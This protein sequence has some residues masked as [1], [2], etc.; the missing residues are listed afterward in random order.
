[1]NNSDVPR[2]D[3][4]NEPSGETGWYEDPFKRHA[5]R[6]IS[7]G[8]ATSLVRDASAP[9]SDEPPDE[10]IRQP[11]VEAPYVP[12][13][14]DLTRA[15]DGTDPET[16]D[17]QETPGYDHLFPLTYLMRKYRERHTRDSS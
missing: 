14:H 12:G 13:P 1:M 17:N 16:E 6:W 15:G 5:F 2:L 11:L 7:E 10:L 9:F 8:R 3:S 4:H